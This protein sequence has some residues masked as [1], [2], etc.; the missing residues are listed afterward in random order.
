MTFGIDAVTFG[1][2]SGTSFLSLFL[3]GSRTPLNTDWPKASTGDYRHYETWGVVDKWKPAR[4][5]DHSICLV[6]VHP[7]CDTP[8]G[9]TGAMISTKFNTSLSE[10]MCPVGTAVNMLLVEPSYL[11][12][13]DAVARFTGFHTLD[14]LER[15]SAASET[16]QSNTIEKTPTFQGEPASQTERMVIQAVDRDVKLAFI[17]TCMA[18]QRSKGEAITEAM[19]LWLKNQ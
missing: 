9:V 14:D 7:D 11:R 6:S 18:L 10:E 5:G 13:E 3:M 16:A 1:V 19:R 15:A 8:P 4:D 2:P 12:Y 17:G